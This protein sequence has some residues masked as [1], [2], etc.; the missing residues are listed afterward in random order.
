MSKSIMLRAKLADIPINDK[1]NS[2]FSIRNCRKQDAKE[3]GELYFQSYDPGQACETLEE[4]IA[5]IESSFEGEYGP[6]WFESSKI[7]EKDGK[8]IGAVMVVHKNSR[9]IF[10]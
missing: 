1:D 2:T 3:L 9:K 4:S 8:L 5:D 7:I 10:G 6:F